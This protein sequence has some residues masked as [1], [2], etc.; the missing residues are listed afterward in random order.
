MGSGRWSLGIDCRVDSFF[1]MTGVIDVEPTPELVACANPL[2]S[3]V[4]ELL[5][6]RT[7]GIISRFIVNKNVSVYS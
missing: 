5:P 3:S 1:G 7:T 4:S 6:A 2:T